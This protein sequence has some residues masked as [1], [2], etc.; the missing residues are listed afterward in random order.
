MKRSTPTGDLSR[1]R[2]EV[3]AHRRCHRRPR[4]SWLPSPAPAPGPQM[5][6]RHRLEVAHPVSEASLAVRA[7]NALFHRADRLAAPSVTTSKRIAE[8]A[9]G[10]RRTVGTF[11]CAPSSWAPSG[12]QDLPPV[13]VDCRRA[14]HGFRGCPGR[15]CPAATVGE[16]QAAGVPSALPEYGLP[17]K[18]LGC[19]LEPSRF[20]ERGTVGSRSVRST[21][22]SLKNGTID[23]LAGV[24]RLGDA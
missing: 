19:V 24:A 5:L 21:L 11:P 16:D 4:S 22:N 9:E 23:S 8:A 6:D 20:W 1:V 18:T 12:G 17:A 13:P 15:S 14:R 10:P 3:V 2:D 7:R